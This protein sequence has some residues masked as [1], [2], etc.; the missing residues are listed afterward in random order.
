MRGSLAAAALVGALAVGAQAADDPVRDLDQKATAAYKAKD[1]AGFLQHSRA[2]ADVVPWSVRARYNLACAYALTGAP[3]DAVRVL[4]GIAAQEVTMDVAAEGDLASLRPLPA[5]Q[6]LQ[7]RMKSFAAPVGDASPAFTLPEKDLIT[8]G[9]AHDPKTGAFFVSSV[10]HRKIVRRAADGAV[11]DFAKEGQDGLMSVLALAVDAPR[12]ALW[13]S[14]QGFPQMLGFQKAD[15]GRSFLAEYDLDT[16][17]LRRRVEPPA[18]GGVSD[19]AVLADGNVL[20]SDPKSGGVHLLDARTGAWRTLVPPGALRSPQGLSPAADGKSVYVAD[21]ARGVARVAL[22]G[23]GVRWL[24]TP[25]DLATTGVDG[26]A[27][28]GGWLIAVQN[29]VTPHRVAGW[30]LDASGDRVVSWRTLVRGHAALDEPTLGLVVGPDFLFVANSQ[31]GAFRQDGTLDT[32]RLKEPV[33]LR[34]ALPR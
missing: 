7:D 22:P 32:A 2:L 16:A 19:I 11:T 20:A 13:A 14:S 15:E 9:V 29:G 23:G 18:G 17:R 10:R 30:K 34:T 28:A 8:E 33:V 3:A 1:Y 31:Y 24:E 26:L 12:R 25:A 5:F 6:T 4:E 27:L 21:Y